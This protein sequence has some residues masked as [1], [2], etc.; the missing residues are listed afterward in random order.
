MKAII[1]FLIDVEYCLKISWITSKFY[2]VIRSFVQIANTS[3]PIVGIFIMKNIL[4]I[5][6]SSIPDVLNIFITLIVVYLFAQLSA[7]WMTKLNEYLQRIHEQMIENYLNQHVIQK[8][9]KIDLS[10][11][12]SPKYYDKLQLMRINSTAISQIV[13]NVV[14]LIS[15]L[16]S[17]TVSFLILFKYNPLFSCIIVL[18]YLPIAIYDQ[19]YI[20]KL[21]KFQSNNVGEERKMEYISKLL[22]ILK[23]QKFLYF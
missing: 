15:C 11:F 7:Q 17:F 3:L 1:N 21:Y 5:L 4:D 22:N 12:D 20:K 2:T 18:S 16:I 19:I 9:S 14:N 10:F 23:Y 6:V 8:S 13:W